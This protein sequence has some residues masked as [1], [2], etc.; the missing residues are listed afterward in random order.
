[1]EAMKLEL[2]AQQIEQL[3]ERGVEKALTR[4]LTSSETMSERKVLDLLRKK[5]R[6]HSLL[7]RMKD[8]GLVTGRRYGD[9]TNSK[10]VYN[11]S[12]VMRAIEQL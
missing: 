1:M 7:N 11:T 2:T 9:A 4:F 5:G 10:I 6:P 12:E 8:A 3:I